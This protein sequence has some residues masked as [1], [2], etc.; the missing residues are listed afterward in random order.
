MKSKID[1]LKEELGKGTS[2]PTIKCAACICYTCKN[3]EYYT[4]CKVHCNN[5]ISLNGDGRR[6]ICPLA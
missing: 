1:K 6:A 2:L 3:K 4:Y 5:C